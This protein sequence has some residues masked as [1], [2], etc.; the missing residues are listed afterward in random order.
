MSFALRLKR[1]KTGKLFLARDLPRL[2]LFLDERTLPL[3]AV[4]GDVIPGLFVLPR[5][6]EFSIARCL[7]RCNLPRRVA[8]VGLRQRSEGGVYL[9]GTAAQRAG[10]RLNRAGR[11]LHSLLQVGNVGGEFY[12]DVICHLP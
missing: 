7:R 10:C 1:E 11:L 12:G 3:H 2:G 9:G 4:Q 8:R 6:R 5:D